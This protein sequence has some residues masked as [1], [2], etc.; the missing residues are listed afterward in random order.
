MI[1]EQNNDPACLRIFL[2]L[3]C[4]KHKNSTTSN[5]ELQIIL[6]GQL[7]K[8]YKGQL[9]DPLDK[10]PNLIKTVVRI[11][12]KIHSFMKESSTLIHL[13]CANSL[14]DILDNCFASKDDK[15]SL[16]LIF[17]EPMAVVINGGMDQIGQ[18]AAALCI[19]RLLEFLIDNKHE[20]LFDF[21]VPKFVQLFYKT[22][23][24]NQEFIHC[25]TIIVDHSSL[26]YVTQCIWDVVQKCTKVL[27]N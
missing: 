2:S 1:I 23:C 6:F 27:E 17:Y 26:K 14:V 4:E 24:D 8:V 5:K 13:A 11:C 16:S 12:E 7:A 22:K 21:I 19:Q 9:L 3:L 10:P 15:L 20:Q 25:M 18:L